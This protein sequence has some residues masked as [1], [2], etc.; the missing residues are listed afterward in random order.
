MPSHILSPHKKCQI[1]AKAMFKEPKQ[2]MLQVEAAGFSQP[3]L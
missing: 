2:K 1:P 3:L